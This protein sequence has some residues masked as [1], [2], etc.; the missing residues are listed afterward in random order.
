[1]IPEIKLS[2]DP[3]TGLLI[4]E[5]WRAIPGHPYLVSNYGRI[6]RNNNIVK[7]SDNGNGYIGF[8]S[9]QGPKK[10]W[11]YVH[12]AVMLA[13]DNVDESDMLAVNHID[14]DTKNNMRNNLE[15][16]TDK[17]NQR[18]SIKNG[19]Y[20]RANRNH[21]KLMK[22]KTT[23]HRLRKPVLLVKEMALIECLSATDAAVIAGVTISTVARAAR[24]EIF[25]NGFKVYYL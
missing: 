11:I 25:T 19:R 23:F 17:E 5:E 10:K 4:P 1:M 3:E 7:T 15:W 12:R 6:Q 21:S 2:P 24:Q 16:L 13:F 18:H 20:L 8:V 14:F 22:E 9:Y